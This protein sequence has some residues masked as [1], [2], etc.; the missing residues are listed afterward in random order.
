MELDELKNIW[1]KTPAAFHLKDEAQLALMLQGKSKSI[2][3][4]LKRSVWLE[5][6]FTTVAGILLLIYALYL[7]SGSLKWTSVSILVLFVGYSFYYVKKL[8]LLAHFNPADHNLR[9]NLETLTDNLE[10]Y[11]KFYKRSYTILYPV[12]FCLGILFGGLQTGSQKFFQIITQP[13][14]IIELVVVALL[15][16]LLS[17]WVA[18]WLFKRLYGNHLEK[19]KLILKD[20]T[21]TEFTDNLQ[22]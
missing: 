4:K 7:P 10:S 15:F 5:L 18:N 16:F 19:L 13:K 17:T 14:T 2:V 21:A 3:E 22:V 9:S 1:K 12:Y 8:L 11:L 20:L 6:M